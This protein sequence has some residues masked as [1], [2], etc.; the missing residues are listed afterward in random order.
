[1]KLPLISASIVAYILLA[2]AWICHTGLST[3]Y[4]SGAPF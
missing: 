1:M 3:L 4:R 2:T